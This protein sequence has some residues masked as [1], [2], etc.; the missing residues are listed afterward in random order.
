MYD[1]DVS[2]QEKVGRRSQLVVVHQS[3]Y[4]EWLISRL[5]IDFFHNVTEVHCESSCRL[6][7]SDVKRFWEAIGKLPDLTRLEA[8]GGVTRPGALRTLQGHARLESLS[9]RWADLAPPDYSI[10]QSLHRLVELN[11]SETPVTDE[12]LAAI[13]RSASLTSL[14][15]HHA[16]I[17]NAGI[18]YL[19]RMKQFERLW[20]SCTEISDEGISHLRGH[21][22]L[23][24]LD[25]CGTHIS[26]KS[27]AHLATVPR[28]A[29]LDVSRTGITDAGLMHLEG[30]KALTYLN[31]E[32]TAVSGDGLGS[33]KRVPHLE[34][35]C[36]GTP[37]QEINLA[38]LSGCRQ[39]KRLKLSFVSRLNEK[40]ADLVIPTVLELGSSR[41]LIDD[42]SL[43]RLA[44]MPKLKA[45][46]CYEVRAS[47]V[48]LD[49]FRR[50]QPHCKLISQSIL[51]DRGLRSRP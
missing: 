8:S 47:P 34:E 18:P 17:T 31:L 6:S 32:Y 2:R 13:S 38:P 4:P 46:H 43:G 24:D 49:E 12:G 21:P 45:I 28:L 30:H 25:L 14:D 48:V 36:L 22:A 5:G 39:L 15:L 37:W 42:E 23:V 10:I 7:D 1:C 40:L 16:K 20:I 9:L 29:D 26:D 41:T 11:L 35:L 50:M 44:L 51:T 19:A 33:L 3:R 27:L